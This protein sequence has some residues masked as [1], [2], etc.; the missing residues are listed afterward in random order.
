[1][2]L[3][4]TFIYLEVRGLLKRG[5]P[6]TDAPARAE[7]LSCLGQEALVRLAAGRRSLN[8]FTDFGIW[9]DGSRQLELIWNKQT[10]TLHRATGAFVAPL[11]NLLIAPLGTFNCPLLAI[12]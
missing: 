1:M 9:P 8:A 12:G 10:L 5:R 3:S 2:Y 7:R 11:L 4:Y 6:S